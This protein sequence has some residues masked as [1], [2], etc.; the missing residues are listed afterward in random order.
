MLQIKQVFFACAETQQRNFGRVC[1]CGKASFSTRFGKIIH[2]VTWIA[3]LGLSHFY[4]NLTF[5]LQNPLLCTFNRTTKVL[6]YQLQE[7][8][9]SF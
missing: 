5:L 1:D 9:F 7:Q 3:A 8:M 2:A 6:Q 4:T